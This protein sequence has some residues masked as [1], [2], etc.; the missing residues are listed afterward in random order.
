MNL[1]SKQKQQLKARAHK[2]NPVVIV[3][4]NGLTE[5]VNNEIDQALIIHELIKVRVNSED[6]DERRAVF[7]EICESHKAELVQIVGK[8]GVLYRKNPEG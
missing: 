5:N 1:T 7:T 4:G 3:G 2:L 8:I 6:R